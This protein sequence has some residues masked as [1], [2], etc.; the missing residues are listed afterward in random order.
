M[1]DSSMKA[2]L[3][4]LTTAT[5]LTGILA[6]AGMANAGTLTRTASYQQT[7]FDRDALPETYLQQGY[8]L[9]DITDSILS[10]QKF[11]PSQNK[12]LKSVTID[13]SGDIKGDGGLENRDARAQTITATLLGNLKLNMPEGRSL[14]DLNPNTSSVFNNVSRYDGRL[15]YVGTSGRTFEGLTAAAAGRKTF[16]D[17]TFLQQFIGNGNLDFVFSAT[18]NSTFTGSGNVASYVDTYARAALMVTYEYA[19]VPRDIPEPAATVGIGLVAGLGLLSR[20]KKSLNK[21]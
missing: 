17:S 19:E 1:G 18:A 21:T 10:I 8:G 2:L 6:T 3:T 5:A 7:D 13:F 9:T 20:K 16:T 14:F 4:G 15:D 11:S 12:Q